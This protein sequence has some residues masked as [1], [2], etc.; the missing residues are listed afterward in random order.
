MCQGNGYAGSALL[1]HWL[2]EHDVQLATAAATTQAFLRSPTIRVARTLLDKAI[3]GGSYYPV[4]WYARAR[5]AYLAGDYDAAIRF[6]NVALQL[7]AIVLTRSIDR[8]LVMSTGHVHNLIAISHVAAGRHEL[9]LDAI[10]V[11]LADAPE[12]IDL[13]ANAVVLSAPMRDRASV[14]RHVDALLAF[15]TSSSSRSALELVVRVLE[16]HAHVEDA[17]K[18]RQRVVELAQGTATHAMPDAPAIPSAASLSSAHFPLS[19]A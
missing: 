15:A 19:I 3:D 16:S 6:C 1:D 10:R 18:C 14:R 5:L 9:A 17:G 8:E 7:N 2:E 4:H 13:H 12:D 11:G